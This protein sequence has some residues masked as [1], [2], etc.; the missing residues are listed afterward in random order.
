MSVA[1]AP[2]Q[3]DCRTPHLSNPTSGFHDDPVDSLVDSEPSPAEFQHFGIKTKALMFQICIQGGEYLFC[4]LD[5]N[6]FPRLQVK[7]LFILATVV[8]ATPL[9]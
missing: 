7:T 8:D 9:E 5:R 3:Q 6:P 4:R 2:F 1:H